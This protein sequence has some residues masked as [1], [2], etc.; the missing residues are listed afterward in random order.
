MV[1]LLGRLGGGI[2]QC[3]WTVGEDGCGD[4]WDARDGDFSCES[5]VAE[6]LRCGIKVAAWIGGHDH[7]TFLGI[8]SWLGMICRSCGRR[9]RVGEE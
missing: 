1:I 5:G 9:E 8:A 7:Y 4:G 3:W 2:G 6:D